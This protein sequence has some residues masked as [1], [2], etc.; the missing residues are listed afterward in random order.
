MVSLFCP[1]AVSVSIS[2]LALK[3]DGEPLGL[4]QAFLVSIGVEY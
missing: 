4:P 1:A 2:D 3:A